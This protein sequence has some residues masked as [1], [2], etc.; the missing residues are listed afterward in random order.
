MLTLL[1]IDSIF[2]RLHAY[3]VPITAQKSFLHVLAE[4]GSGEDR[5]PEDPTTTDSPN[6]GQPHV[7]ARNHA[8]RPQPA[9]FSTPEPG[10]TTET[11]TQLQMKERG[12]KW[13][14]NRSNN[15]LPLQ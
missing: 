15:H 13:N 5:G 3:P 9:R 4:P 8:S 6:A 14:E 7:T 1:H 11:T 2:H 10:D 12:E